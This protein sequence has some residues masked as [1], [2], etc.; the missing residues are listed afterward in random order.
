MIYNISYKTL[1]NSKPLRIRFDK[2]DEFIR[3][4]DGYLAL[5]GSENYDA[6]Y[7]RIRYLISLISGI[8]YIFSR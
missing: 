4:Y 5:F 8:T 2:T 3:I 7:E 1:I 6:I